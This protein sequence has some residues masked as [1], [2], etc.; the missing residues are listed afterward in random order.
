MLKKTIN[1]TDFDGNERSETHYFNLTKAELIEMEMST[2]GGVQQLI[3]KIVE[4][5]DGAKIMSFFKDL[6]LRAYGEKSPDGKYFRKSKEISEA[7][8]QTEAYSE[9]FME[10]ASDAGKATAF[11]QGILPIMPESA[12][13]MV[14]P[15]A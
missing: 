6:I 4:E 11:V 7:F 14:A 8:S 2:S 12:P 15:T 1:Y 3:E 13:L 5:R 10:I 9:L